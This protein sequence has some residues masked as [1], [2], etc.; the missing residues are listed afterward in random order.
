MCIPTSIFQ[1]PHTLG[2]HLSLNTSM[3]DGPPATASSSNFKVIFEKALKTYKKTTG[4]DRTV[5]PLFSQLQAC[6]S[7][8]AIRTVL[9]NQVDQFIQSRSGD[10][11]LKTWLN[12][13][14]N[15]LYA[16]SAAL[17]GGVGVVMIFFLSEM[18]FSYRSDRFSLPPMRFLQVLVSS[19]W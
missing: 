4:Q 12:P 13:T 18:T 1:T 10:E 9:Q 8:A 7:P 2:Y 17:A 3:S 16:F 15:V 11:R 6:D 5:H 14:I 19:F